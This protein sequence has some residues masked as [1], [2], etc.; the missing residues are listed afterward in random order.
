MKQ[1]HIH[2]RKHVTLK[3]TPFNINVHVIL[4]HCM[5]VFWHHF[6]RNFMSLNDLQ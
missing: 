4:V 6:H 5:F 2:V 1:G 3:D